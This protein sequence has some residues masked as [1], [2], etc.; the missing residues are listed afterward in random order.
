MNGKFGHYQAA[1]TMCASILFI[2][3]FDFH[4]RRHN[5]CLT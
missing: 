1:T 3:K 4:S 2:T 5:D